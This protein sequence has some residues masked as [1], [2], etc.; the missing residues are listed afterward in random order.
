MFSGRFEAPNPA[1]ILLF[2]DRR[3]PGT[4]RPPPEGTGTT[5]FGPQAG[6]SYYFLVLRW[7]PG[8]ILNG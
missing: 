7:V 2:S 4:I 6:R 3:V 8:T 1:L 5:L